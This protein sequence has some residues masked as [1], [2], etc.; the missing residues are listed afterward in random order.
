MYYISVQLLSVTKSSIR[1]LERIK[2]RELSTYLV[3]LLHTGIFLQIHHSFLLKDHLSRTQQVKAWDVTVRSI[4]VYEIVQVSLF[5][6]TRDSISENPD[7]QG[8][9]KDYNLTS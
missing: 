9:D 8:C 3:G 2:S 6:L 4:M 5:L 1:E 7:N